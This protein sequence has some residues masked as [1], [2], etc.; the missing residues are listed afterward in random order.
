MDWL[1]RLHGTDALAAAWAITAVPLWI[2]MA[3]RRAPLRSW[4]LSPIRAVLVMLIA[5]VVADL[6]RWLLTHVGIPDNGTP[7]S[8]VSLICFVLIGYAGGRYSRR[9][10]LQPEMHNRG[11]LLES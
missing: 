10:T 4:L 2:G 3:Q 9:G 5:A 6:V 1:T 8:I 11:S 7:A